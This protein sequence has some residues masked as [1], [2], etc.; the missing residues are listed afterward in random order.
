MLGYHIHVENNQY[1]DAIRQLHSEGATTGAFA[2][3][4]SSPNLASKFQ[5]ACQE[6]DIDPKTIPVH[7]C[8][9]MN[10]AS[11]EDRKYKS[12]R[13]IVVKEMKACA[14]LGVGMYVLHPGSAIG[15]GSK[16]E[17][18]QNTIETINYAIQKTD[19][20]IVCV[21]NMCGGVKG[22]KSK[23]LGKTFE[24]LAAI[25]NGVD[26]KDRVGV[27]L[28]TCHAFSAGY[29]IRTEEGFDKVL[30]EFETVIGMQYLKCLHINDSLVPLGHGADRHEVVGKGHVGIEAFK[31][32]MKHP[33]LKGLPK[34]IESRSRKAHDDGPV[35]EMTLL[36]SF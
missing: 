36:K 28:D 6:C 34:I 33:V 25:I 3:K 16:E 26:N 5:K 13:R 19:D 10:C 9:C 7:C 17:A 35:Y 23:Q 30:E 15:K 24:D 2:V 29:D 21:E 11:S 18:I 12:A 20:V 32:V 14:Q 31:Y 22:G 4:E 8:L 1:H 27:C